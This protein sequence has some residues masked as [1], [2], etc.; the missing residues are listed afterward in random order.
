VQ[1][2]SSLRVMQ[3]HLEISPANDSP[4]FQHMQDTN[5]HPITFH[6]VN[7]SAKA[8]SLL[9][10][11]MLAILNLKGT[12]Y[13]H[14]VAYAENGPNFAQY[15]GVTRLLSFKQRRKEQQLLEAVLVAQYLTAW[16]PYI[17][18]SLMPMSDNGIN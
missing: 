6:W 11:N 1:A 13:L 16:N 5:L 9:I 2:Y 14:L 8:M 10:R 12:L 15:E 3:F 4:L 7:H 18:T 17:H